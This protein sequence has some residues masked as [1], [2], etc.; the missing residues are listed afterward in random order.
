[1]VAHVDEHRLAAQP[2]HRLRHLHPDG[3]AAQDEQAP[4]DL[5]HRGRLAARPDALELARQGTGGMTGSAPLA[6]TTW[7]AV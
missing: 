1:V 4:R 5:A 6:R 3:P 2:A 7:S